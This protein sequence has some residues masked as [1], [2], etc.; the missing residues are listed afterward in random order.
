M[1][2]KKRKKGRPK[3]TIDYTIL[4]KLCEIFCTGEECA[5]VLGVDYETLNTILKRDGHGGYRE[6]Y[7]IH[8]GKGRASLRRAQYKAALG[9][10]R[11]LLVWMGKQFLG[12]TDKQQHELSGPDGG[13]IEINARDNLKEKI[14]GIKNRISNDSERTKNSDG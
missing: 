2:N 10:D 1:E 6:Y 4:E 12:Q 7:N 9:G 11:T 3:K 14:S 8:E 5:S 13:P